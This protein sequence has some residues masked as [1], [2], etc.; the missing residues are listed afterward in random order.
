MR[1]YILLECE[2]TIDS[3]KTSISDIVSSDGC[4][5]EFYFLLDGN[6]GMEVK[7]VDI[8]ES[9]QAELSKLFLYSISNNLLSNNDLS[10]IDLSSA[11]DRANAVYEYDL[12]E[13]PEELAH[14]KNIIE[15]DEFDN[16]TFENDELANLEG[17]LILI[18]NQ[19]CQLAL[20]KY[21]YPITLLKKDSGF[22]LMKSRGANR[23]QKLDQDI[24]KIN[25]KFEFLKVN[26]K[27]YILDLKALE[28]FFGFHEAIKNV[29][30]KGIENIA[31]ANIIED[32]SVL[33]NRLDD[34]SFSRKLLKA[35]TS[36]PVLGVIPNNM[37]I[38]FSNNHP[39][40]KGK[41]KYSDNGE[42]LNLKTKKSQ[43]LFLKLLNDD[44]LQSELTKKY[45]DSMAKDDVETT[46]E[47]VVA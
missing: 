22:N 31:N 41:F 2:M 39:A 47:A 34:I 16:F 35:T 38:S 46:E 10:L 43:N 3:L 7:K 44:F 23:F 9:D 32:T 6:D 37:I 11:D 26:G 36:S 8:A 30:E 29:A 14:L 33:T 13:V 28:R 12:G 5:A 42:Q 18:G 15:N 27:Y 40:L 4:S 24:L 20:Y 25:P 1:K 45:Y 17:I 21:Q 19:D